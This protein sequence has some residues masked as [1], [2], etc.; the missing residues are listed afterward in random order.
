MPDVC[1]NMIFGT[2]VF[3]PFVGPIYLTQG[4]WSLERG[5]CGGRS[6]QGLRSVRSSKPLRRLLSSEVTWAM[7]PDNSFC[8]LILSQNSLMKSRPINIC[9]ERCRQLLPMPMTQRDCVGRCSA[10]RMSSFINRASAQKMQQPIASAPT[11]AR[12]ETPKT[13]I[14]TPLHCLCL[15]C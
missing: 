11:R 12:A 5:G 2:T 10:Y 9:F 1:L 4:S 3:R 13:Q 8:S 7:A 6:A 14:A 15:L